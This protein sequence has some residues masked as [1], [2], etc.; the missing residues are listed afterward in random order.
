MATPTTDRMMPPKKTTAANTT[1]KV[2][3]RI[4]MRLSQLVLLKAIHLNLRSIFGYIVRNVDAL[5]PYKLALNQRVQN[6]LPLR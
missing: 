3:I 4:V 5:H 1:A 6:H 2:I